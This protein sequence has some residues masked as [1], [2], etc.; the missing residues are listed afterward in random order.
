MRQV[1]R[2]VQALILGFSAVWWF[3]TLACRCD[4]TRPRPAELIP[5][6][7]PAARE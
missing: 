2:R 7:R 4:G 6:D 5:A 1:D 3:L